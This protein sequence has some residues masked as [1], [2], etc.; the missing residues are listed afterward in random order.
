MAWW[1]R[2]S[3][4]DRLTQ[5]EYPR[6]RRVSYFRLL[7]RAHRQYVTRFRRRQRPTTKT[8]RDSRGHPRRVF[9]SAS[10]LGQVSPARACLEPPVVPPHPRHSNAC[11]RLPISIQRTEPHDIPE[12]VLGDHSQRQDIAKHRLQTCQGLCSGISQSTS[13][14]RQWSSEPRTNV[15]SRARGVQQPHQGLCHTLWPR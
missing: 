11:Y 10:L 15:S 1:R 5:G 9:R 7:K 13:F 2:L 6:E 3:G 8:H 4:M 12:Q 14:R